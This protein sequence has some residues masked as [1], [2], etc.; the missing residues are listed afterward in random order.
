MTDV[1]FGSAILGKANWREEAER[2]SETPCEGRC[3]AAWLASI[4]APANGPM[5]AFLRVY[6]RVQTALR[7]A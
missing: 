7:V 6:S 2:F 1:R 5:M 3:Q 4:L